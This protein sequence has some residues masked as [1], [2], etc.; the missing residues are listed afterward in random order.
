MDIPNY[1]AP[2]MDIYSKHDNVECRRIFF[3]LCMFLHDKYMKKVIF[4]F[5]FIYYYCYFLNFFF[6][7]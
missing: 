3:E 4:L 6:F 1:M 5:I 2:L 7:F